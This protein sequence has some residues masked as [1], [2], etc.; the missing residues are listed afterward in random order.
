MSLFWRL[1]SGKKEV[2]V[3]CVLRVLLALADSVPKMP[4]L[5][6]TVSPAS[7]LGEALGQKPLKTGRVVSVTTCFE[8]PEF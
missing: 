5:L 2:D 7:L 6:G 1:K 3:C 4:E 8:K